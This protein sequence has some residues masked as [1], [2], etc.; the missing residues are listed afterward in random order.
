MTFEELLQLFKEAKDE[1]TRKL[2]LIMYTISRIG[3]E[4]AKQIQS[5]DVDWKI[6]SADVFSTQQLVFPTLRLTFFPNP[7]KT[8]DGTDT[9]AM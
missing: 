1:Q 9:A 4:K 3:E 7:P 5:I 8:L 2:A 6:D